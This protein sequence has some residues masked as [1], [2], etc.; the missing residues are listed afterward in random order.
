MQRNV[1]AYLQ[2]QRAIAELK[3]ATL[4]VLGDHDG[5][6]TNADLGRSLGIYMGH[7]RHEGH[8]SRTILD[9]LEN[10]GLVVQDSVT[11]AWSLRPRSS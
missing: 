11:K 4:T 7:K 9:L 1:D 2:A 10:E 6:L 8:V 5:G 3:A